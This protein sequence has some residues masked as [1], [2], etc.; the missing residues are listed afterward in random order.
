MESALRIGHLYPGQMNLYGDRG[1]VLTLLRRLKWRGLDVEVV[2][3]EVG[4]EVDWDR[5]SLVF[6]G[7]GEDSHQVL[8]ADDFRARADQLLKRFENGLPMLAICGA[9]QLLGKEYV[10]TNQ[11]ILPGVGYF[12]VRTE[13]GAERKIGDV[14]CRVEGLDLSL[15]T[16]VGFEN[17]G[18]V[19]YLGP[20]A[21][22]LARVSMGSGNNGVDGSEGVVRN[23]VVGTYLHGSL[24]PKNPH[25]ADRLISWALSYAEIQDS[26]MA[27]LN[28]EWEYRAHQAML[29]RQSERHR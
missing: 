29:S 24:L 10:T 25:L 11:T 18:G 28:D 15:A 5:I 27:D 7:G 13:P 14:V 16:L 3:I 19:T 6:M 4:A 20:D 9:Y 26:F 1:N 22:P 21:T 2:P 23:H 17:H 12:D 8:I